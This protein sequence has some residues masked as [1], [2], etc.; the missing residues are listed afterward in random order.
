MQNFGLPRFNFWTPHF[1]VWTWPRLPPVSGRAPTAAVLRNRR[2]GRPQEGVKPAKWP[3]TVLRWV[4][5][6][7]GKPSRYV[8]SHLS[9]LSLPSLGGT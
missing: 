8:T 3:T 6:C 1:P 7:A 9:Q 2:S 5:V 4:T